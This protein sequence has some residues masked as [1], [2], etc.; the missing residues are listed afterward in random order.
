MRKKSEKG[1]IYVYLKDSATQQK[2]K[3]QCK[4]TI[5]Q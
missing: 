5:P 3:Q 1:W 2:L 4:I